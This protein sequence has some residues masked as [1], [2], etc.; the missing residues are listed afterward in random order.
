MS[1]GRFAFIRTALTVKLLSSLHIAPVERVIGAYGT[2]Y[3][4]YVDDA[5]L[6][7][8]LDLSIGEP[9]GNLN[10]FTEAVVY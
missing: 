8:T 10:K 1:S 3:Q 4:P 9:L 2:A 5:T 6:Y 7:T